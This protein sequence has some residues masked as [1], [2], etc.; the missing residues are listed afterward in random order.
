MV[1]ADAGL[2][3]NEN[4]HELQSKGYEYI[5]GARIKNE[6]REI[7]KS[8]LDLKLKDGESHLIAKDNY[9]KLIINYSSSRAKKDKAN[10]EKALTKLEKQITSGKLTKAHI[11]NRGYNKYLKLEGE[12]KIS[13]DHQ[14]FKDDNAWDGLKGYLTNTNLSKEQIMDNYN[15]LWKIEKAFRI[16]KHDLK[17]R[18]IYH[19]VKRRIEAHLCIAFVA[20]K[21]YKELERQLKQKQSDL[22]PEKAM[23]IAKTIY[24]VKL[25]NPLDHQTIRHTV[26]ST[27][28]QKK[29]VR[30]FDL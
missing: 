11:N 5:L 30:L 24:S 2:L 25:I 26:V 1:I 7:Q 6:K 17:I 14:K 18:P 3:S 15:H 27:E 12:L 28:E 29:L 8:I 10:R 23:D 20:Y 19:Q 21:I 4:I 13:I 9:A 16:S 22:S